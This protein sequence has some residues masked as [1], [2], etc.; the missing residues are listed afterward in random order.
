VE[1]YEAAVLRGARQVLSHSRPP[2]LFLELHNQMIRERGGDPGATL[3]ILD[4]FGYELA[5]P[6]GGAVDPHAILQIPITRI[7]ARKRVPPDWEVGGGT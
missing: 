2:V 6:T 1:G 7:A 5:S 4:S 3:D